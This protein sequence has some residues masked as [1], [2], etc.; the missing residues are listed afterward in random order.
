MSNQ[1][2]RVHVPGD[3]PFTELFENIFLKYTRSS[4]LIAVDSVQSGTLT[5]L[6]YSVGLKNPGLADAFIA[7]IKKMNNNNKVTL[8]TGYNGTDL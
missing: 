1:I 6:T 5:E 3:A 7:E 8:I 2:L 4:E